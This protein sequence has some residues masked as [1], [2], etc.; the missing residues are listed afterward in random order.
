MF[1]H[2]YYYYFVHF[3]STYKSEKITLLRQKTNF[4]IF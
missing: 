1:S 3:T 4:E 2:Y